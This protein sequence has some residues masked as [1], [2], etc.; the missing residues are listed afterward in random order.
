MKEGKPLKIICPMLGI[1]K[2]LAIQSQPPYTCYDSS[3]FVADGS[4]T[5]RER[6]G[7]RPGVG[8]YSATQIGSGNPIRMLNDVRFL[9]SGVVISR[10][11]AVA[12]GLL[13]YM[14]A[15]NVMQTVTTDCTL[16]SGVQLS[17]VDYLQKLYIADY[18]PTITSGSDGVIGGGSLNQLTSTAVGNFASAGVNDDDHFVVITSHAAVNEVQTVTVDATGGYF[19]LR[20]EVNALTTINIAENASA[21]TVQTA[22]ETIYGTGNVG[23]SG[24]G[25]GPF[26][27]TFQGDLAG[28]RIDLM[29]GENAFLTGGASTVTIVRTTRG[30]STTQYSGTYN[31]TTVATVTVTI[32]KTLQAL[33]SVAFYVTRCPKVYDPSAG[34]LTKWIQSDDDDSIP[35]GAIPVGRTMVTAFNQRLI[36]A[37]GIYSPHTLDFSRQGDP[38]DWAVDADDVGAAVLGSVDDRG[39]IAEPITAILPHQ[40]SCMIIA[41]KT[42]MWVLRGDITAGSIVN[43]SEQVGIIDRFAWCTT[44]EGVLLFMS[45]TGVYAM[46]SPCGGTPQSVSKE[47]LPQVFQNIDLANYTVSMEYCHKYR[48]AH[49]W[50]VQNSASAAGTNYIIDLQVSVNAGMSAAFWPIALGSHNYEPFCVHGRRDVPDD[51]SVVILGTR[52]GYLRRFQHNLA[53]DDSTAFTSYVLLGPFQLGDINHRGAVNEIYAQIP[54]SSGE[55]DWSLYVADQPELLVSASAAATGEWNTVGRTPSVYPRREGQACALKLANGESNA[56]WEIELVGMNIL[57]GGRV[58]S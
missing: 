6:G 3:N 37:G 27:V 11:C 29:T 38:R 47:K 55:I 18:G 42:S 25:G 53:Q 48:S 31:I 58:R 51:Y 49:V 43:L 8:K 9:S 17:S 5:E 57:P 56:R 16:N 30:A 46:S 26:T 40:N 50:V 15:S 24:S 34:T 1:N 39:R 21:A 7:S 4:I 10:L 14:D 28:T 2:R 41:A 35:L 33:T 54:A 20:D 44:A 19:L 23:V 45:L 36:L 13:Y 22:L 52:N 12:N 32:H